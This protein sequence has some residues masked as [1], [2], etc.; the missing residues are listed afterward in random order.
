MK[1]SLL[2]IY[3]N[4][5]AGKTPE[6]ENDISQETEFPFPEKILSSVSSEKITLKMEKAPGIFFGSFRILPPASCFPA[7][8]DVL[9]IDLNEC[10]EGYD[11][12]QLSDIP[13]VACETPHT[14]V[15]RNGLLTSQGSLNSVFTSI[16]KIFEQF[17]KWDDLV[18]MKLIEGND[19]QEIFNLSS[20]VT[21]DTVYLTDVSMKM[22]VHSTPTLMDDISAIW[23]Y[24]TCYGYMPIHIMNQLITSGELDKINQYRNAF[25]LD[26][27]TFNLPYTCKNIFSANTLKAHIF[28]VSIYSKPTQTHKEIAEELGILLAPRICSS[29]FFSARAGK[30]YENFFQ[31]ILHRRVTNTILIQQQI[32]IFD[33]H[34][35]DTY[36][37]LVVDVTDQ[38]IDRIQLLINYF[39]DSTNDCKAFENG[40]RIICICHMKSPQ[41]KAQFSEKISE[42][43]M[44]MNLKGALS[45]T[46]TNFC[47]MDLY[48]RQAVTILRFCTGNE[49]KRYLF[50]QEEFGLYGIFNAALESHNAYELCHPDIIALYEFDRKNDTEY[51]KTLYQYLL[52]DRNAVKA[53]KNLYIHRNTMSYRL[54]KLKT[55]ISFD[56]ED[57]LSRFY[58]LNSISLL[59][60]QLKRPDEFQ[61]N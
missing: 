21:P 24:Q 33:W 48:Y 12:G 50:L 34:I 16:L 53:A 18:K 2:L 20:M 8:P 41:N 23:R 10:A 61:E 55:M 36:F 28:I 30:V 47:D 1:L 3:E 17:Q 52:C 37:V 54:Q 44:K 39:D 46:F 49:P 59:K 60:Y 6:M 11:A 13:L 7:E 29:P 5:S 40:N 43:L 27:K 51:L 25:T 4:L 26:T 15:I 57:P 45:K 19:L 14:S 35:N 31:D 56:E 22:Y 38:P 9:Y 42:L 32:A 58:I